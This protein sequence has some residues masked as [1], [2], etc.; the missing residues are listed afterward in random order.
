M[1]SP[2]NVYKF[3]FYMFSVYIAI[4]FKSSFSEQKILMT[5]K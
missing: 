4:Y 3:Y 1:D 5:G 2:L